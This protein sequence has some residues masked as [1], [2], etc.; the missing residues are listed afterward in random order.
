M[1]SRSTDPSRRPPPAFMFALPV[2]YLTLREHHGRRFGFESRTLTGGGDLEN[3]AA[4]GG[5]GDEV[6]CE[7]TQADQG[8]DDHRGLQ[9]D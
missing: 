2:Y 9:S 7:L 1:P 5:F 6:E 8:K 3:L 4:L